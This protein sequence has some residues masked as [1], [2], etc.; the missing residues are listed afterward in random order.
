MKPRLLG[1]A[2]TPRQVRIPPMLCGI[3]ESA[4]S[5]DVGQLTP[6]HLAFDGCEMAVEDLLASG[7]A[8]TGAGVAKCSRES[9]NGNYYLGST[10]R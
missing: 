10:G 2:G 5:T 4:R 9:S 8:F 7:L 6:A 3:D 1:I